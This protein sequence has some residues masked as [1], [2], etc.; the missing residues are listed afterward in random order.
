MHSL[1]SEYHPDIAPLVHSLQA[2]LEA[3]IRATAFRPAITV[4]RWTT[5]LARV[6]DQSR[7]K[8]L[9]NLD[10]DMDWLL[11][12]PP[13]AWA[14]ANVTDVEAFRG[15]AAGERARVKVG[16][17][18]LY[19][20][21]TKRL[22]GGWL[23]RDGWLFLFLLS[24]AATNDLAQSRNAATEVIVASLLAMAHD[25]P[26]DGDGRPL[27]HAH[28]LDRILRD[29]AHA[30][31]IFGALTRT[32][33]KVNAA[34]RPF[35]ALGPTSK[36]E[37]TLVTFGASR[38]RD[39][40]ARRFLLS[41][42]N[43]ARAGNWPANIT[44]L[45]RGFMPSTDPD[46]SGR[47]NQDPRPEERSV[48]RPV[49]DPRQ[50]WEIQVLA[51]ACLDPQ[52]T[53]WAGLAQ[54]CGAAGFTSR[55]TEE[56]ERT[57]DKLRDQTSAG[58]LLM[59]VA[60]VRAY[61][62]GLL[63][64]TE[65]GV[66][67]G[68]FNPGDGHQLLPRGPGDDMGEVIYDVR[69]GRPEDHGWD[70][71]VPP[72]VWQAILTKFLLPNGFQPQG[73]SWDD[74]PL[75][76]GW[77]QIRDAAGAGKAQA[78][79]SHASKSEFRPFSGLIQWSDP[80]HRHHL[81]C[82]NSNDR[83]LDRYSW[84]R[85]AHTDSRRDASGTT[86]RMADTDGETICSWSVR[87]FHR[88][89]ADLATGLFTQLIAQH[90][91]AT[92]T[93]GHVAAGA[94]NLPRPDDSARRGARSNSGAVAAREAATAKLENDIRE[95]AE[96]ARVLMLSAAHKRAAG[97]EKGACD[98]EAQADDAR[99]AKT[100]AQA[101][102]QILR[103]KPLPRPAKP[104]RPQADFGTAAAVIAALT[105]PFASG[106]AP[107]ALNN[108]LELIG[109]KSTRIEEVDAT[110]VRLSL[111]VCLRRTDGVLV[112]ATGH[113]TGRRSMPNQRTAKA[114]AQRN[115]ARAV[116]AR[117]WFYDGIDVAELARLAD[118][119]VPGA[120]RIVREQLAGGTIGGM[121]PPTAD[122]LL[123]SRIPQRGLRWAITAH[124]IPEARASMWSA[125]HP[126]DPPPEGLHP[127]YPALI[128]ATY[129][130]DEQGW[131]P[132]NPMRDSRTGHRVDTLTVLRALPNPGTP[133]RSDHLA[134]LVGA[135]V[136]YVNALS[137]DVT[138]V[139]TT[140]TIPASLDRDRDGDWGGAGSGSRPRGQRQVALIGCP[141]TD[142]PS[143]TADAALLLPELVIGAHAS[144]LC[145][146]CLRPPTRNVVFPDTYRELITQSET[147]TG[148]WV[149]CP[150]AGCT[151]DLGAGPEVMWRWDDAP[152]RHGH[153]HPSCTPTGQASPTNQMVRLW[154]SG[155]G[156]AVAEYGAI[157]AGTRAA[158]DHAHGIDEVEAGVS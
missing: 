149:H 135:P 50:R 33:V 59:T 56:L 71:G 29:E 28:A 1:L 19:A 75:L 41:R 92:I 97:D 95:R 18:A 43:K 51:G 126:T 131:D 2:G 121:T 8:F 104:T 34:G 129:R 65:K 85:E 53:T 99:Q 84:R 152:P 7:N 119:A 4:T 79:G 10:E 9:A 54:A 47:F 145:R 26:H 102:L 80:T 46:A 17:H 23:A 35:D 39:D 68:Q 98:Y 5:V 112:S 12:E 74:E 22:I 109:A 30:W 45:P 3:S 142:C 72:T 108:A 83:T 37:W 128:E 138:F 151:T 123:E 154:A 69:V 148:T 130:Q 103:D 40:T 117:K 86:Y 133:I 110:T 141:W 49:P 150:A 144:V 125:L 118:A 70:W 158:Y 15:T 134:A 77:A 139:L 116:L 76:W 82:T 122:G 94:S 114:T 156:Y 20:P 78:T 13:A 11:A 60:K 16:M 62:T 81:Y 146:V 73:W 32:Y 14:K 140:L 136:R 52:V 90:P 106:P 137:A 115:Q 93:G 67:T 6:S 105:G 155:H 153:T 88:R 25:D 38:G 64:H 58:R 157:A 124:P 113:S 57:L 147:R 24:S 100:A 127:G 42:L 27:L 21:G 66:T 44:S 55:G 87:E 101:S 31:K 107:K 63:W 143:S 91:D 48:R 111:T 120:L 61:C 36:D 89:W 96:D 132:D